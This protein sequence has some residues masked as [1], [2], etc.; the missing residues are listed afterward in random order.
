MMKLRDDG[1]LREVLSP[2]SKW[3]GTV[4][5]RDPKTYRQQSVV[6]ITR[7]PNVYCGNWTPTRL[8]RCVVCD[9]PLHPPTRTGEHSDEL[10]DTPG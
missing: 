1:L 4:E 9:T 6:A 5:R 7:C 10:P 2:R 8:D 3:K